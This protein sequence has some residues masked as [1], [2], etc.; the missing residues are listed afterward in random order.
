MRELM[1][2][3]VAGACDRCCDGLR[4]TSRNEMTSEM[5]E[6]VELG[7]EEGKSTSVPS[8]LI[9]TCKA[10]SWD[11]RKVPNLGISPCKVI[12]PSSNSPAK[13]NQ[14]NRSLSSR[15]AQAVKD[16]QL[17]YAGTWS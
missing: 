16:R 14:W 10:R 5:S 9:E 1:C 13:C 4:L 7:L 3:L 15:R 6:G 2:E 17:Q 8:I 12:S 11:E